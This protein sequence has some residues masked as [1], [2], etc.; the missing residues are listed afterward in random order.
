MKGERK[1]VLAQNAK[2]TYMWDP[3]WGEGGHTKARLLRGGGTT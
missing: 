1:A 2:G 3:I